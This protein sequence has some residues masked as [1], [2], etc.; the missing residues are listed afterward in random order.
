MF[1]MMFLGMSSVF[2]FPFRTSCDKIVNVT[3]TE[4]A[5]LEA[6]TNYLKIVNY[7]V[8]GIVPN[9]ITIYTH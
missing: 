7:Q 1:G 5:S 6:V 4:G 2:A 3:G 9:R 8:C